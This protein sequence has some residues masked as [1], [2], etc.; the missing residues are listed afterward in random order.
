MDFTVE[1]PDVLG[2][3]CKLKIAKNRIYKTDWKATYMKDQL[4][5]LTY[6][7]ILE[8]FQLLYW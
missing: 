5:P 1:C 4:E 6:Q 3:P 2:E 8:L 7:E